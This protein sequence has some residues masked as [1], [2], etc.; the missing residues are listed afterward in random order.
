M[1]RKQSYRKIHNQM[2]EPADKGGFPSARDSN[3]NARI[4]L[5]SLERYQ[6]NWVVQMTNYYKQ[7]CCCKLCNEP[8][9]KHKLLRL[10]R[11]RIIRL[12]ENQPWDSNDPRYMSLD[13]VNEYKCQVMVDETMPFVKGDLKD[14]N[15]FKGMRSIVCK[16]LEINGKI[17]H[18]VECILQD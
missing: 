7:M 6:P 10:V 11:G 9:S 12:L 2:L 17:F 13:I 15:V 5:T 18:R 14:D 1:V 3:G 16:R 4:S 8:E